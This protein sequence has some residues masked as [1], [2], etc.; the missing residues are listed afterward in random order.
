MRLAVLFIIGI[1]LSTLPS[2]AD[3]QQECP[4]P[5]N[6]ACHVQYT[7][8]CI[9]TNNLTVF[10]GKGTE[11]ANPG[12]F[13]LKPVFRGDLPGVVVIDASDFST[14]S[15]PRYQITIEQEAKLGP[16]KASFITISSPNAVPLTAGS[17]NP[18][19]LA[20]HSVPEN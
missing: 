14:S 11:L 12:N 16:F 18:V 19:P 1:S 15:I 7:V 3:V 10:L 9:D 13:K 6:L 17:P 2:L 4:Q 8:F 5:S 20:C